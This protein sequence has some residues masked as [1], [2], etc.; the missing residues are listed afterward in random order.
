MTATRPSKL[1]KRARIEDEI[2]RGVWSLERI[3]DECDTTDE[4]VRQVW[5][6]MR[7]GVWPGGES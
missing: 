1:A 3:A 7:D 6:E 5:V 2:R 4:Y